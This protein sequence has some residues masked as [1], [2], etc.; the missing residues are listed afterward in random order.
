MSETTPHFEQAGHPT[1]P[2]G[3]CPICYSQ[4]YEDG[5]AKWKELAVRAYAW[6]RHDPAH[7]AWLADYDQAMRG[8]G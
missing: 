3:Q 4:G 7:K 5:A 2:N 6:T 1:A 8:E